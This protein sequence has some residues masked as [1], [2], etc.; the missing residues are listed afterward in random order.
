MARKVAGYVSDNGLIFLRRHRGKYDITHDGVRYEL[1]YRIASQQEPG[2][3]GWF[4]YGGD[5][6]GK[7]LFTVLEESI[8]CA[9]R[10]IAKEHDEWAG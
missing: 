2:G 6:F 1:E 4:L 3:S 7:S 10:I 9:A 8:E 5:Y